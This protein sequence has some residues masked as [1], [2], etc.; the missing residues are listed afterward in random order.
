M[1]VTWSWLGDWTSLPESPETLAHRL[2]MLGFPVQSL[3][4]G[5]TFDPGIVVG[6]ILEANPHPNADRL[7]LCRVDVGAGEPLQIV[8]GASNVAAGQRVAVAQVGASLPDGM[9]LRRA[10]IRGVESMG[11]ICSQRELGLSDEAEG[12]WVLPGAPAIGTP[13]A[14]IAGGG[15]TILDVEITSN[16]TDCLSVRGVAREIAAAGGGSLDQAVKV[17]VFITDFA[18]FATLNQVMARYFK[19]PYPARATVAVAAL[20]RGVPVE[21]DATLAL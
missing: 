5:I 13:L 7:R 10:K 12:I 6:E 18:N 2:A 11:M 8:C 20:P 16:R 21:V 19:E 15:E 17:N 3:V 4:R 9:K 1:K 14:A